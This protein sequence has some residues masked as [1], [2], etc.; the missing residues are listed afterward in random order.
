MNWSCSRI[1]PWLL[2]ISPYNNFEVGQIK[3]HSFTYCCVYAE[4]S[5]PSNGCTCQNIHSLHVSNNVESS[6]VYN[7]W[8][9]GFEAKESADTMLCLSQLFQHVLVWGY[10]T[11]AMRMSSFCFLLVSLLSWVVLW[12]R[13]LTV[14]WR[15]S[16]SLDSLAVIIFLWHRFRNTSLPPFA[17]Y[18][19]S[20]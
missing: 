12:E 20:G 10:H 15:P 1:A 16:R 9:I 19:N 8:W 18:W 3:K 17:M 7:S 6:G 2:I 14:G 13:K 5:F 4:C 11:E